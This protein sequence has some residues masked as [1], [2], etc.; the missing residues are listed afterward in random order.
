MPRGVGP[1]VQLSDHDLLT[2]LHRTEVEGLSMQQCARVMT[3]ID[4]VAM[5]KSRVAGQL[6]RFRIAEA[7]FPDATVK[8]ENKDLPRY[9][10]GW[11]NAG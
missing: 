9:K 10:R 2:L 8:P 5:T 3:S 11:A 1:K 6:M 7:D 4:G